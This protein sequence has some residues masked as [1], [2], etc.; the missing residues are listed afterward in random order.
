MAVTIPALESLTI[1]WNATFHAATVIKAAFIGALKP[2]TIR[3][4]LL[5]F[6][7]W[8]RLHARP[9]RTL[10]DL[11]GFPHYNRNSAGEGDRVL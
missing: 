2:L 8:A 11:P 6:R 10:L 4:Q 7:I 1:P 3:G 5:A 9:W